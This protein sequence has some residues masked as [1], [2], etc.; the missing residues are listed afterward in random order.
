ME[1]SAVAQL[2]QLVG[3]FD[4]NHS[5]TWNAL[6]PVRSGTPDADQ[7]KH[8]YHKIASAC[9]GRFPYHYTCPHILLCRIPL[10]ND[11]KAIIGFESRHSLSYKAGL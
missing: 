1:N 2:F 5:P 8:F 3:F 10:G 7:Q 4:L 11:R 9:I 6:S